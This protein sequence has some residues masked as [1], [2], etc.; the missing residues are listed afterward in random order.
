MEIGR[1]LRERLGW[2]DYLKPFLEKPLP[3]DLNWTFTLGSILA[4]L[5]VVEA[6]SGMLLA[7][8]YNPS[9]DHAYQSIHYIMD[10][11]FLG[12]LLRGI[13]HW[14]AGAMVVLVVLH[15]ITTFY[16][17]AYKPPRELTWMVGTGLLVVTLA[18]GFTGYLLPWDQKAY[19]ATVV[20]TNVPGDI[21][22]IGDALVRLFRGG[23]EVSGLTLTRFY[24]VHVLVL[25]ALTLLFIGLHIY[26][27]RVHDVAGDWGP[28]PADK[29]KRPRFFPNHLFKSAL[30]FSIVFAALV[31][32]A[33]LVKPHQEEIAM[34]PD[35]SYLPRPEWYYMWLFELLTYFPGAVEVVGSLAVPIG[36]IV[37]LA[38][39]PFLTR[40][41]LRRPADRPL[42]MAVGGMCLVGVVY[43]NLMGIADSQPYGQI[44][45]VPDRELT[46]VERRGLEEYVEKDCA[47]CHNILGRGGRRVGPDLSNVLAKDRSKE[48]LVK[49]IGD[50]KAVNQ[51][52]TMPKYDL[53]QTE[54][55]AL[56]EFIL[57]LDFDRYGTRTI[58][59]TDIV[60]KAGP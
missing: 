24:S 49:Y 40:S 17:G 39:L 34:T 57:S 16:Y 48:W 35:P 29:E 22:L 3:G 52:S 18:F 8:Y 56:S 28:A 13:H 50:P 46:A 59:R 30:A 43:L 45:V 32:L 55:N 44:V 42:A 14:G 5:F 47:Y 38:F 19:W 26:L 23:E 27:V 9:P 37:L 15:M 2:Q 7:M 53:T 31:V 6:V 12:T 54:L 51:W 21:P 58:S 10:G 1:F 33:I 60:G 36:G 41:P 20:G 11:V 4:L 25:P